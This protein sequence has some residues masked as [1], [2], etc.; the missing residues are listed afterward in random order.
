MQAQHYWHDEHQCIQ[1][2]HIPT[3]M[4]LNSSPDVAADP[5]DDSSVDSSSHGEISEP[6]GGI[7][8]DHPNVVDNDNCDCDSVGLNVVDPDP[9]LLLSVIASEGDNCNHHESPLVNVQYSLRQ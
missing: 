6:E 5:E 9:G 2:C 7:R 4:T 1:V 8:F 3:L